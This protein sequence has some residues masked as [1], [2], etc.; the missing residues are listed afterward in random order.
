MRFKQNYV[1][2]TQQEY[3]E[4]SKRMI[5]EDNRQNKRLDALELAMHQVNDINATLKVLCNTIE[6]MSKEQEKLGKKIEVIEKE[7]SNKWKTA[8]S[9]VLTLVIGTVITFIASHFG[10]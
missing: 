5:E 3:I 10:F 2:V 6:T 9:Y 4:H 1:T 8:S 7:D